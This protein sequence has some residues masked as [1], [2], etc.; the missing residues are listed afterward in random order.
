[1]RPN[2]NLFIVIAGCGRLGAY[3]ANRLSREGCSVVVVDI[4]EAAFSGLSP[5]FS[6]FKIEGDATEPNVLKGAKTAEADIFIGVTHNDNVNLMT[7]QVAQKVFGVAKVFVRVFEPQR[8]ELCHTLGIQ[9]VCPT[10][11]AG[12]RMMQAIMDVTPEERKE[13]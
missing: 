1:M 6:G 11:I 13:D 5:D 7:A 3:L 9:S 4:A 2:E 8:V 10:T 12:E